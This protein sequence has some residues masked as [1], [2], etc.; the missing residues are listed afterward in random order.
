MSPPGVESDKVVGTQELTEVLEV[1]RWVAGHR[2]GNASN[3]WVR[4]QRCVIVACSY[5]D[6]NASE[7]TVESLPHLRS[8]FKHAGAFGIIGFLIDTED[9]DVS[10][11]LA[12]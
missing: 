11:V 9:V 7:V 5:P 3:R 12:W 2:A 4:L 8:L 1:F 10:V 6:G